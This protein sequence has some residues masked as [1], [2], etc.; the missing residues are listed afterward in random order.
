MPK[1]KWQTRN[2]AILVT[3]FYVESHES[4]SCWRL[5]IGKTTQTKIVFLFHAPHRA[6]YS[7]TLAE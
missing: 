1:S 7:G 4:Q 6:T 2:T 3:C 5:S